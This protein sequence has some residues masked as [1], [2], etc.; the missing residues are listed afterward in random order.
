MKFLVMG[1]TAVLALSFGFK[2]IASAADAPAVPVE[3]VD[4][5]EVAPGMFAILHTEKFEYVCDVE[6]TQGTD[7]VKHKAFFDIDFEEAPGYR[8]AVGFVGGGKVAGMVAAEVPV[9]SVT[10]AR[11]PGLCLEATVKS[12]E[13]G[14]LVLLNFAEDQITKVITLSST[15]AGKTE[16][17]GTCRK[18]EVE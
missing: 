4:R 18:N 17:L 9:V 15:E 7:V 12:N 1:M 3:A 2:S 16:V 6:S 11:C 13:D 5:L 10:R 14:T 8:F